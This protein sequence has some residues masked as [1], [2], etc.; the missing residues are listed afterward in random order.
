LAMQN[1]G[2]SGTQYP[3]RHK[4]AGGGVWK[5]K[6]EFLRRLLGGKPSAR[7]AVYTL[8][9]LIDKNCRIDPQAMSSLQP[10]KMLRKMWNQTQGQGGH[11][12]RVL[13]G[14]RKNTDRMN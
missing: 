9:C 7:K 14:Q 11:V 8:N 10:P 13:Q 2:T 4:K 3:M 12:F 6:P 1:V 5:E